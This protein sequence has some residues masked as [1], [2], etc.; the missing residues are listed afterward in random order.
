VRKNKHSGFS[1]FAFGIVTLV[2]SGFSSFAFLSQYVRPSSFV[3]FQWIGLFLPVLLMINLLLLIFWSSRKKNWFFFPLI[4]LLANSFYYPRVFQFPFKSQS[5][6]DLVSDILIGSYNVRGFQMDYGGSSLMEIANF[7]NKKHINV[8]CLQEVPAGI[9]R[10]NLM[11]AFP[12]FPYMISS[13]KA[14]DASNVVVFSIF[15][16]RSSQTISF[17]KR[18]NCAMIVD[19][20]IKGKSVRLFNCHLQTTNW[21]QVKKKKE[22]ETNDFEDNI[23]HM[24]KI[25]HVMSDNYRSRALQADSISRFIHASSS[26]VIVCGD[27]N[28]VPASYTYHKMKGN[29]TD[30]FCACGR[31]YTHTYRYLHKLLRIDYL[32]C[33]P[34]NF[35]PRY[36][37]SPE[38]EYSDHKPIIIGLDLEQ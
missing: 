7:I 24:F 29:L 38:I 23:Y 6:R 20:D 11:A 27:F 33:S 21:N 17:P 35:T 13:P 19:L 9:S 5:K 8:L 12:S 18:P 14:I 37:E 32:F 4:A 3:F 15:P 36:Y 22:F 16:I 30:S 31:G 34:Q 2:F 1:E 25:E 28:D 10:E 26:P